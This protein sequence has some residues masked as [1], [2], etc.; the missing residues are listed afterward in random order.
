MSA[1]R[2]EQALTHDNQALSYWRKEDNVFQLANLLNNL[3]VLHHLRGDYVQA[4]SLLEEALTCAG[5]SGYTR[6]E[7][8]A[9]TSIGEFYADLDAP[10]AALAAYGK[11]QEI[12]QRI[13]DRQLLLYLELFQAALT[14]SDGKLAQ[15]RELLESADRLTRESTSD[16]EQGLY[17]LEAG[18][19][20]LADG[21]TSGAIANLEVAA[22]CFDDSGQQVEAAR[23][24]F[25]LAIAHHAAKD[26]QAATDHLGQALN[27]GSEL[28]SQHALIVA[29]REA[30]EL[31]RATQ[32]NSALGRQASQLLKQVLEF[33]QRIPILRRRVRERASTIPFDPPSLRIQA[34]GRAQVTLNGRLV[35][36]ADW[37][38]QDARH[39]FFC[40]LA[41]PDGMTKE[42]VGAILWPD[43]SPAQLKRKFKNAIYRLRQALRQ[44]VVLFDE[45]CYRFNRPR[46]GLRL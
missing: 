3:G 7:G 31:L 41:H 42:E 25:H 4:V 17:Q 38:T 45:D 29:G 23:A 27:L 44:E 40:L 32:R 2:Y 35:S 43:S 28:E 22:R 21:D 24:H 6:M 1:G 16:F 36:S 46:P 15:A 39:L 37:Q 14:R 9:L 34:L 30:K 11:A 33:E 26:S 13:D 12:A 18:R 20:A 8:F 10:I 19:L 5:Q